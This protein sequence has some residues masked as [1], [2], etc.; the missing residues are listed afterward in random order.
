PRG[1]RRRRAE[2]AARRTLQSERPFAR[3]ARPVGGRRRLRRRRPP[4]RRRVHEPTRSR[5]DDR[6]ARRGAPRRA[7]GPVTSAPEGVLPIDKPAGVTS[8]DVVTTVRRAL[9]TRKV[10]HA[11]TLDPMATGLLIVGG[12]S[13]TRLLRFLGDLSK[14]Y[15]GT[16]RLGVETTT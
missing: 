2:A 5:R 12:G 1:R 4:P 3:R 14:T 7:G 9:G 8:H 10:G 15:E 11:G 6:A 13:A 16:F